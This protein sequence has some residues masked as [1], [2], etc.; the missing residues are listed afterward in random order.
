VLLEPGEQEMVEDEH[1]QLVPSNSSKLLSMYEQ[2]EMVC[3]MCNKHFLGLQALETHISWAHKTKD[4]KTKV[5]TD[6]KGGKSSTHT[7]CHIFIYQLAF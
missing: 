6:A 1:G 4:P 3:P 5:V 7:K 2:R